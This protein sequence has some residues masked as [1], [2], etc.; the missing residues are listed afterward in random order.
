M[1]NWWLTQ[2]GWALSI[3]FIVVLLFAQVGCLLGFFYEGSRH[4]RQYPYRADSTAFS[5][6]TGRDSLRDDESR[7]SYSFTDRSSI[8]ATAWSVTTT[9]GGSDGDT[10]RTDTPSYTGGESQANSLTM[11]TATDASPHFGYYSENF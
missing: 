3:I 7:K 1:L 8:A 10:M 11:P 5:V 2:P 4:P 6:K 9:G